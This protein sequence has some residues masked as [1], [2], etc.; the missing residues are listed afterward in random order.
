MRAEFEGP[1]DPGGHRLVIA[2]ADDDAAIGMMFVHSISRQHRRCEIGFY[3]VPAAR[4]QGLGSEAVQ[5]IVEDLFAGGFERIEM[6]TTPDNA[7]VFALAERLGFEHEGT[8]RSRNLERGRR[9][10][11]AWFGLLRP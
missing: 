7:A 1:T 2:R 11:V 3:L 8:L 10:D 9:V 6:T 5:F 4:G